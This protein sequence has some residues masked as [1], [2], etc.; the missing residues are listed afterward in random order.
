M[1]K[2]IYTD[3]RYDTPP[4]DEIVPYT[5]SFFCGF[6]TSSSLEKLSKAILFARRTDYQQPKV[7]RC[8]IILKKVLPA[9]RVAM[10]TL[11]PKCLVP[12][13]VTLFLGNI[14]YLLGMINDPPSRRARRVRRGNLPFVQP[15][16]TVLL[17]PP[18][19]WTRPLSGY[20]EQETKAH[21]GKKIKVE[22]GQK[23]MKSLV[24]TKGSHNLRTSNTIS[25]P[26]ESEDE[27]VKPRKVA[28]SKGGPQS[29]QSRVHE[30]MPEI[31]SAIVELATSKKVFKTVHG[32]G[33]N[34][35]VISITH[36]QS[37]KKYDLK[38]SLGKGTD[39][40]API[41]P[42]SFV[43]S[44]SLPIRQ[45]IQPKWS[46]TL[47][48]IFKVECLLNRLGLECVHCT[49]RKLGAY[50]DHTT[51]TVRL[52]N[53]V[54]NLCVLT[55][56]MAPNPD[57]ITSPLLHHLVDRALT[58]Q[59]LA[60]EDRGNFARDLRKYLWRPGRKRSGERRFR[61]PLHSGGCG[62]CPAHLND[63]IKAFNETLATAAQLNRLPTNLSLPTPKAL[64]MRSR[65]FV[66]S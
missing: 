26:I 10:Q 17:P 49:S 48:I 40:D 41:D 54:Q 14:A 34:N 63:L 64:V 15:S 55:D 62:L 58:T 37:S 39:D 50:C 60:E 45:A 12:A 25:Y 8:I 29:I 51:N 65:T 20:R 6:H 47:C 4:N 22:G 42:L 46:C 16:Q 38:S 43:E 66:S 33:A 31:E 11:D 9:M 56:F 1:P 13:D 18:M 23:S 52:H 27:D 36:K 57:A 2:T 3:L 21:K 32:I 44:V 7:A 35:I 30:L 24:Y 28:K 61:I 53:I 5:S 19:T 59:Q